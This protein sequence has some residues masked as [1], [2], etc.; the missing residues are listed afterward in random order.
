M[1]VDGVIEDQARKAQM[2]Q[3]KA[4]AMLEATGTNVRCVAAGMELSEV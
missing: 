2:G 3:S 1:T 4:V